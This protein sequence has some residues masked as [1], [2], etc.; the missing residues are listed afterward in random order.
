MKSELNSVVIEGTVVRIHREGESTVELTVESAQES[1]PVTTIVRYDEATR[2]WQGPVRV[3][4][5]VRIGGKL[6]QK[7]DGTAYVAADYLHVPG[8]EG[9]ER[10]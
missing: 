8:S 4:G 6:A 5:K 7:E 1:G 9:G 2:A 3:K 10:A